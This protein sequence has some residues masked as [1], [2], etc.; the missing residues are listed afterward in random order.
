MSQHGRQG[1]FWL[2][3]I[4]ASD[5]RPPDSLPE[6]CQW[7]KGQKE[8]G[9]GTGYEHWQVLVAF[10]T[11]QSLRGVKSIFGV[12]CHGELTRSEAANEYVW[13]DETSVEGTRF[14]L[15]FK[16][17]RRNSKPDWEQI[18]SAAKSGKME[19]IPPNLRVLHYRTLKQIASDFQPVPGMERQCSVFFGR[20]GTGKSRRAYEEAG[21]DAYYKD[22]RTKFWCGYNGEQH[23]IIDEFRGGIDVSH[24]LRWL[25]RYPI[26]V[27]VKG[28]SK[29][30]LAT[31]FWITSNLPPA[32]WWPDLDE[33]TLSAVMR[34]MIVEEFT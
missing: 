14:E 28:S 15:G 21:P 13:K 23:V 32:R 11:K 19:T 25:D 3:T 4:P 22:P 17:I 12:T 24:I 16:P 33:E 27:E 1:I 7:L 6:W 31:K 20:T 5:W 9:E 26:R 34:R 18:W 30:L 2:L 10:R 29:P 8:V